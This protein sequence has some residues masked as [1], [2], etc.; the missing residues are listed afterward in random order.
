MSTD[1]SEALKIAGE[2]SAERVGQALEKATRHLKKSWAPELIDV[3]RN[4]PTNWSKGGGVSPLQW[5][6]IAFRTDPSAIYGFLADIGVRPGV[7]DEQPVDQFSLMVR[8]LRAA[9]GEPDQ[10]EQVEGALELAKRAVGVGD[11]NAGG[12]AAASS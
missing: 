11:N 3:D 10:Q 2:M 6:A 12:R 7:A 4:T 5:L 8:D 1:F 9:W